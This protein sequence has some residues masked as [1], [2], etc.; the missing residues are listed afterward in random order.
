MLNMHPARK[1]CL[2][3]KNADEVQ[4]L[5]VIVVNYELCNVYVASETKRKAGEERS[6]KWKLDTYERKSP[7]QTNVKYAK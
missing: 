2:L 1:T 5:S 7:P 4:G 3:I 6:R